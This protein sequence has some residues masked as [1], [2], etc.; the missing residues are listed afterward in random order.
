MYIV[1][2]VGCSTIGNILCYLY[3]LDNI[4]KLYPIHI[5]RYY[6]LHPTCLPSDFHLNT[7]L[8]YSHMDS[9]SVNR[10]LSCNQKAQMPTLHPY[11]ILF[12]WHSVEV[13]LRYCLILQT[14]SHNSLRIHLYVHGTAT[15]CSWYSHMVN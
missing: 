14:F 7:V 1:V 2:V 11:S 8:C 10:V 4:R 6:T 3:I 9:R 5:N 12:S 15:E 13:P